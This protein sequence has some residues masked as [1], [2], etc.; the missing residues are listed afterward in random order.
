MEQRDLL[1]DQIEQLGKVLAEILSDFLGLKSKGSINEGIKIS[2]ERLQSELDIDIEKL[3]TLNKTKLKE[4][5]KNLKLSEGHLEI[6]SEYL[7]EMGM[8]KN[9]ANIG[10][11]KLC[12]EKAL[13]LL[14]VADEISNTLSF[15]R[16]NKK[17]KIENMLQQNL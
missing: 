3:I 16:I 8:V 10:E 7:K 1:K 17:T 12:L 11:A 14:D 15:D 6:L 5:V 4:Y 9:R 13:E 2:K